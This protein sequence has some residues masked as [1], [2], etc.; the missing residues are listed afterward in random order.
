MT[1]NTANINTISFGTSVKIV[2]ILIAIDN[3]VAI[4]T[5]LFEV[6]AS[7]ILVEILIVAIVFSVVIAI[8]NKAESTVCVQL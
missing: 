5:V 3:I 8:L 2:S 4:C 1:R 6:G 7:D